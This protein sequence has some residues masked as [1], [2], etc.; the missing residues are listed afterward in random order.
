V[1]IGRAITRFI[2]DMSMPG[3]LQA[4]AGGFPHGRQLIGLVRLSTRVESWRGWA[5]V[6]SCPPEH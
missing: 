3:V 2:F 6:S 5:G 4:L 1:G